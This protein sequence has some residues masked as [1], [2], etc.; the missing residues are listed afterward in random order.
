MNTLL[1]RNTREAQERE[2]HNAMIAERYKEMLGVVEGQINSEPVFNSAQTYA[3]V[4]EEPV[5][6]PFYSA[7]VME[8][9]PQVTEYTPTNLAASLFTTETL[10]RIAPQSTVGTFAPTYVAPAPIVE[11]KTVVVKEEAYSLSSVAKMAIAIFAAVVVLMLTLI[12][13]NTQTIYRKNVRLQNLEEKKQELMERN[14]EI[15]RYISELQT[16]ESI[17]ERA[18]EAGLLN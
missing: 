17:I 9:A 5:N 15:Q 2:V 18:T 14:E 11:E 1:E 16:E 7:P 4:V 6:V 10:D 3:P 12:G 13:V 8:Q